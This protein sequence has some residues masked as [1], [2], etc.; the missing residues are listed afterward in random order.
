MRAR[1]TFLFSALALALAFGL[2]PMQASAASQDV[3]AT[4]AYIEANYALARASVALIGSVQAKVERLNG[5]LARECPHAGIGTPEVEASQPM[6]YEVAAA[7]WSIAYGT[8]AG[9]IRT[10]VAATGRLH[11]SSHAIA[12]AAASYARNLHEFSTLPLPNLC[13]DVRSWKASGFQV[14]PAAALGLDRRAEAIEL[15]TV[16][17]RLLRPYESGADASTLARTMQLETKIEENEFDKGQTD[18]IQVLE[19]LG[20]PQ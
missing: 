20:L 2:A 5:S 19:T 6:S 15:N 16:P 13:A 1:S 10:F 12:R 14:V 7:L 8:A 4:H 17:P 3:A 11:W 9:P 18:W